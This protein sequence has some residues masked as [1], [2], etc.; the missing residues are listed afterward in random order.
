VGSGD[1]ARRLLAVGRHPA[2]PQPQR[3]V[4][5]GGIAVAQHGDALARDAAQHGV[6]QTLEMRQAALGELHRGIDGGMGGRA[7]EQE[8]GSAE[9]QDLM[10]D[11]IGPFEPALDHRAQ[12]Q[13]DLAQPTQGGGEQQPDERPVARVERR[14]VLMARQRVV[15]RLALVQARFEDVECNPTGIFHFAAGYKPGMFAALVFICRQPSTGDRDLIPTSPPVGEWQHARRSS[16]RKPFLRLWRCGSGTRHTRA[17]WRSR[18][19]PG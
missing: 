18:Q 6:G 16:D 8:L 19:P 9:P 15:E 5:A 13:I 2:L 7:Q 3:R 17:I 1:G 4:E 11:R 14:K 12:H 10:A